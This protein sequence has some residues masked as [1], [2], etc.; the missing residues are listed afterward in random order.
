VTGS[1]TE[2][3]VDAT[4]DFSG[5]WTRDLSTFSD[6]DLAVGRARLRVMRDFVAT[7]EEMREMYGRQLFGFSA[8]ADAYRLARSVVEPAA[9][10][11]FAR[12][13]RGGQDQ[14][15][16]F[17][18]VRHACAQF[19]DVV[20]LP[21]LRALRGYPATADLFSHKRLYAVLTNAAAK[22]QWEQEAGVIGVRYKDEIA[23]LF[24]RTGVD[25][26]RFALRSTPPATT[27]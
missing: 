24:A 1:V 9:V 10:F 14:A 23:E 21:L 20:S 15:A 8:L 25:P 17:D 27:N 11:V 22:A 5:E 13:A 7:I 12:K 16:Q 19:R 4:R 26:K 18:A 3:L 2:T 6:E